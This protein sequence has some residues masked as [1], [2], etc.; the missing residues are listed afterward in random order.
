MKRSPGQNI[1]PGQ[2]KKQRKNSPVARNEEPNRRIMAAQA[3]LERQ[4]ALLEQ[5]ERQQEMDANTRGGKSRR[6]NKNK[7]RRR[8]TQK[9]K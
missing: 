4:I 3:R 7:S 9:N 8:R 5:R 1:S 2:S 6:N